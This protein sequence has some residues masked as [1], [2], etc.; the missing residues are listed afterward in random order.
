[1]PITRANFPQ[2]QSAIQSLT[3]SMAK[4]QSIDNQTVDTTAS[5]KSG[6]ISP[7]AAPAFLQK[8]QMWQEDHQQMM[9]AL[10][11]LLQA[12]TDVTTDLQ[13]KEASLT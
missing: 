12:V 8:L 6:W 9:S 5:I 4:V 7:T 1:M 10:N 3:D 11:Q 13:K 2:M